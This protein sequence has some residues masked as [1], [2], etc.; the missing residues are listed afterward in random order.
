MLKHPLDLTR[1]IQDP[2]HGLIRLSDD[3][4]KVVS[5]PIFQRLRRIK[6]N[7]LLNYVFPAATHTRF[8]HSLGAVFVVESM[9]QAL[10]AN[11]IVA[12]KKRELGNDVGAAID[13]RERLNEHELANLWKVARLAAL[14]HDL[15]HGP[16][17]HAFDKF[18][19]A[20]DRVVTLLANSNV[21]GHLR[22]REL[23]Q[24]DDEE[25]RI[26]HEWM[27]CILLFNVLHNAGIEQDCEISLAVAASICNKPELLENKHLRSIVPL[28]HDL[29]ASAPADADRMDYVERDSQS[30]GVTYGLFDRSR[31]LKSFLCYLDE[32]KDLRLG[33]KSSGF[34]AIENFVQARFQLFVQVYYHKTN[35]AVELML[36]QIGALAGTCKCS[37]VRGET[38]E[39]LFR[40]YV[41]LGDDEFLG[42]LTGRF[43]TIKD[44]QIN[45]L[46]ND[47]RDRRLWK[48]VEDFREG[49]IPQ[50][51]VDRFEEELKENC[52]ADGTSL[53]RDQVKPQAT[54]D[55]EDGAALLF[56]DQNGIYQRSTAPTPW[57][58]E[59]PLMRALAEEE[60]KVVR[61]YYKGNNAQIAR[62][63][64][65]EALKL[66]SKYRSGEKL[67]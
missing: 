22:L 48:R 47:I 30:C 64:R 63:C 54:K 35:R 36:D 59:S 53:I 40:Q 42:L 8:E 19:P 66:E 57:L 34:R 7:G 49:L 65:L 12:K 55:L 25:E 58:K 10:V 1:S 27:S 23:L 46:A 20:R 56:R 50:E 26:S 18:A 24:H 60:S 41:D 37:I 16:L 21:P 61:V 6:Q 5:H 29:I 43:G 45:A 51:N 9:L 31:V 39:E 52:R 67:C 44:S 2:V 15:G 4:L 38:L 14:C 62:T 11:T 13:L 17:S 28:I 32:Q 3:E 33:I